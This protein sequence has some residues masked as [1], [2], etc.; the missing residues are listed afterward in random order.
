MSIYSS[1]STPNSVYFDQTEYSDNIRYWIN[2]VLNE[3]LSCLLLKEK[4]VID[5]DEVACQTW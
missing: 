3:R 5:D 2:S 1:V 4:S